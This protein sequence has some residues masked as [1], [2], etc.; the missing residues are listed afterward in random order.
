MYPAYPSER[1]GQENSS[2]HNSPISASVGAPGLIVESYVHLQPWAPSAYNRVVGLPPPPYYEN[3]VHG[4]ANSEDYTHSMT[5]NPQNFTSWLQTAYNPDF[6][7][8][9]R[10]VPASETH[11][12]GKHVTQL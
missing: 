2:E 8:T 3:P 9:F 10:G 1:S 7:D 6:S 12:G 11:S 5:E 4:Y